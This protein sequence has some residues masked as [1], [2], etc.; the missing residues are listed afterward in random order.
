MDSINPTILFVSISNEDASISHINYPYIDFILTAN[1][2]TIANQDLSGGFFAHI[3][4]TNLTY[5]VA[6]MLD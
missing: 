2:D 4:N 6:S 1:G 3:A 5:T